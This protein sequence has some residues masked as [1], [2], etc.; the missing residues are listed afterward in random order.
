MGNASDYKLLDAGTVR[1]LAATNATGFQ[2]QMVSASTVM[3]T[4]TLNAAA[5]TAD[6]Q[7]LQEVIPVE[8]VRRGGA[9]FGISYPEGAP[10]LQ[11]QLPNG[12][13]LREE[14]VDN[15]AICSNAVV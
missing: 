12:T 4:E 9:L 13:M 3:G 8:I 14:T 1:A 2:S 15:V 7:V 5:L 10:I 11:L 6:S